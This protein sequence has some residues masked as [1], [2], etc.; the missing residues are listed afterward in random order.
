MAYLDGVMVDLRVD[1]LSVSAKMD[2][3][4]E[5]ALS[6]QGRKAFVDDV[7]AGRLNIAVSGANF[8]ETR[9]V[10]SYGNAHLHVV[11]F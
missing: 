1:G 9:E 6:V 7:P 4:E 8:T 11:R 5:P 3:G 10:T 2:N